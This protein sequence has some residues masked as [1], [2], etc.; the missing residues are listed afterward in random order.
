MFYLTLPSNSSLQFYPQNTV[1]QFT[2]QLA[3]PLDLQGHWEVGLAEL[4]YPHTWHNMNEGDGWITV[5]KYGR[6]K[7]VILPPGQ[8]DTPEQLIGALNQL[9]TPRRVPY[10]VETRPSVRVK[11]LKDVDFSYHAITQKVTLT[12]RTRIQLKLSPILK[13]MLGMKESHLSSGTHEGMHVVDVNQGFYSL[14]VY[15]NIIEPRPVGDSEVPLLRI[16]PIEGKSGQMITK[17]YEHIQYIPL[18]QKHLRAIEINIRK[19][20]GEN[21]PFELGKSVITLHFRKQRPH[22]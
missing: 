2:T 19:D 7:R 12:I 13:L 8:Y 16:V 6:E 3:H 9:F 17:T 20:T 15:C 21:V 5:R 10:G 22:F 1:T 11:T 4:Q 14:Y 18:L